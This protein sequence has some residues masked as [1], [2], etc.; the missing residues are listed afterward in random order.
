MKR[1]SKNK[2]IRLGFIQ[3]SWSQWWNGCV[4]VVF[5][6][7]DKEMVVYVCAQITSGE[8]YARPALGVKTETD[9]VNLCK[10]INGVS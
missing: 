7:K 5:Y 10:L 6:P 8:D 2:L 1:L 3:E 9:L 4:F